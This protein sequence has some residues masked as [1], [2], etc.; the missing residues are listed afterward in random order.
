MA[1]VNGQHIIFSMRI[2]KS[3]VPLPPVACCPIGVVMLDHRIA[4]IML[5]SVELIPFIIMSTF[6]LLISPC[7]YH[8]LVEYC[9]I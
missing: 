1:G 7:P 9:S 5:T 8:Y 4:A 6:E 3:N 2:A